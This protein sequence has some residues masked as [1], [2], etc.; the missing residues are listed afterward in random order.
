MTNKVY[1]TDQDVKS[2]CSSIVRDMALDQWVPD[3][4]VGLTRGGL[5]PANMIS[6]YYNAP[7]QTLKVSFRD[8]DIKPE[9]S[10]DLAKAALDRKHILI[11]DDI[12]DT[13]A[14]LEWIKNDWRS[15]YVADWDSTIFGQS[16]RFAVLIN[17]EDSKF[18][19]VNYLGKE[20]NK[21]ENPEWCVFPW[22]E[23][24]R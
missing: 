3:L 20:I 15:T 16:V 9:H 8:D 10:L 19:D 6:Q 14:T 2:W 12:N 1:Y 18:D 5:V 23:W 7:M 4:I 13:G 24:W 17:N 22:E 11:V 21:F